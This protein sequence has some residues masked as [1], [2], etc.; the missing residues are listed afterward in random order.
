MEARILSILILVCS[1]G[2]IFGVSTDATTAITT[3]DASNVTTANYTTSSVSATTPTPIVAEETTTEFNGTTVSINVTTESANTTTAPSTTTVTTV[4]PTALLTTID[5]SNCSNETCARDPEQYQCPVSCE[6]INGSKI[7]D[8]ENDCE[9]GSDEFGCN[10]TSTSESS[11]D[12]PTTPPTTPVVCKEWEFRCPE[13]NKCI[14]NTRYND[15]II[16]CP[17]DCADEPDLIDQCQL[18]PPPTDSNDVTRIIVACFAVAILL[19][20]MLV[21]A[22]FV[23]SKKRNAQANSRFLRL[24]DDDGNQPNT[25]SPLYG[26]DPEPQTENAATARVTIMD[27]DDDEFGS[28]VKWERGQTERKQL[29]DDIVERTN[30][31]HE[32]EA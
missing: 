21:S 27:D 24:I 3:E 11:T 9:D 16:D 2:C 30:V 6:C 13:D 5:Y 8:G 28:R 17:S 19:V 14:N 22:S 32:S 7:C 12:L 29:E 20:V 23:C 26:G 10:S 31:G 18:L 1:V 25:E 15:T 4:I